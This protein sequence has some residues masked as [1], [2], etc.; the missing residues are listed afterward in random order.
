MWKSVKSSLF[1]LETPIYG[2]FA[3]GWNVMINYFFQVLWTSVCPTFTGI[4]KAP[5]CL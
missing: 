3:K 5:T 1:Y 4:N 2:I